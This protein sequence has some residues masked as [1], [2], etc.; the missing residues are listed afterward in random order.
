MTMHE[1]RDARDAHPSVFWNDHK[2]R[3]WVSEEPPATQLF[4]RLAP[5]ILGIIGATLVVVVVGASVL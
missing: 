3:L 2:M 5:K 4:N 1:A